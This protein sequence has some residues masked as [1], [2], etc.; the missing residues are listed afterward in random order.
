MPPLR[1][2]IY[3]A[4]VLLLSGCE[5]VIGYEEGRP[6]IPVPYGSPGLSC[7]GELTC[8]GVSCCASEVVER[9]TFLMGTG[10]TEHQATVETFELDILEVTVGRFRTFVNAYDGTPPPSGAG[11][12][13]RIA[14]SGWQSSWDQHL[15]SSR[16]ALIQSLSCG[17][18]P[19]WTSAVASNEGLPMNC[20]A[21]YVAFAFCAWDGGR[22]PTETEWEYA[23]AGGA[24]ALEY[25][26]GSQEPDTSL[27]V[28]NCAFDGVASS[29]GAA[30]LPP[31]GSLPQG[32][33][34]WGQLDLAGSLHEW[35]FDGYPGAYDDGCNPCVQLDGAQRG[36]RGGSFSSG[37]AELKRT[38]ATGVP[39]TANDD[40]RGFRCVRVPM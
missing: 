32:A 28:F 40:R 22:L 5:L 1:Q 14:G 6:I 25:P 29:C 35:V 13:P 37:A 36:I 26:W 19:T 27:A 33:G 17:T 34:R 30:D 38:H 9:G 39:P 4:T 3:L 20:V 24:Q 15:P 12:N 21:W 7:D 11:A 10:T 18:F 16:A 8:K 2:Y 23:A 31:A